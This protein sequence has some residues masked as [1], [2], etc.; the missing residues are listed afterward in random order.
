MTAHDA[1]PGTRRSRVPG[2]REQASGHHPHAARRGRWPAS[3]APCSPA[4][5]A[6]SPSTCRACARRRS[7]SGS[8]SALATRPPPRRVPRTISSTCCSRAHSD[9]L[10]ARHLRLD[11]RRRRRDER[12]HQQGVH[13]LLR[14]GARRRPAARDRRHQRPGHLVAPARPPTSTPSATSSSK[15]SRCA[16]TIRAISCTRSSPTRCS[17]TLRS[18]GR[19]SARS[20]RSSPS[21]R[22]PS[23]PTTASATSRR[24]WSSPQPATSTMPPSSGWSARRSM[25]PG[26]STA[27]RFRRR[28]APGRSA[29]AA[30]A[31]SAC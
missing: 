16:T 15:R 12:V 17:A 7:A 22:A 28:T 10:R 3:G 9:A 5:C 8:A 30:P 24:T 26:C 1:T 14:A 31:T 2:A 27:R 25:P 23:A 20:R 19:S 29:P 13:L 18:V 11:G 6:S 4:A 21:P